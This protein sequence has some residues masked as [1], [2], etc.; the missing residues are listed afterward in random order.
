MAINP[1]TQYP[2]KIA[3]STPDYP[4]GAAR[5]I[6]LPGDGTGTPWEAALVNDL[7]GFQQ[8]TLAEAAVVPS[9]NPDKVGA[10]QYLSALSKIHGLNADTLTAA[11]ARKDISEGSTILVKERTAGN[12]GGFFADVVLTSSVTPNTFNIIQ[13]TALPTLSLVI[14]PGQTMIE[15]WGAVSGQDATAATQAILDAG[16]DPIAGPGTFLFSSQLLVSADGQKI[17]GA[18]IGRTVFQSDGLGATD[19]IIYSE[20]HSDVTVSGIQFDCNAECYMGVRFTLDN[21]GQNHRNICVQW[22]EV[23]NTLDAVTSLFGGVTVDNKQ[24]AAFTHQYEGVDVRHVLFDTDTVSHSGHGCIVAYARNVKFQQNNVVSAG[25]HGM[26]AVGCDAVIISGNTVK[27]CF[28]SGLGVGA[29][30]KN[31]AIVFNTIDNCDGDGAITVEQNSVQGEVSNNVLTECTNNGINVSFGTAGGAP[32][33]E[34]NNITVANNIVMAAASGLGRI[35]INAYSSSSALGT[36]IKIRGNTFDGFATGIEC[37]WL[38]FLE[39]SK[40]TVRRFGAVSGSRPE[41]RYMNIVGCD[42]FD[43]DG[44]T[45]EQDVTDH[46]IFIDTSTLANSRGSITGGTIQSATAGALVRKEG[47]GEL[48]VKGLKTFGAINYVSCD[49]TQ[50]VTLGENTGPISGLPL[51]GGVVVNRIERLTATPEGA[52]AGRIGAIATRSDAAVGS[53]LYV[54]ESNDAG[55]TGWVAK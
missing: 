34:V 14:R 51:A 24:G 32:F 3:P 5:N 26:E 48:T 29:N 30:T 38:D 16:L 23:N 11:L 31:F 39:V 20:N 19:A 54:K 10:S 4:Y 25:F 40:N 52:I 43:V 33:N 17:K 44:V 21:P 46:A 18:G 35:G 45:C 9:G 22:C 8:A 36:G 27:N 50:D 28:E 1:E 12:G 6:T 15:Q 55:N 13:C 37:T 53:K 47:N 49:G 2:G 42:K 41:K 7:F